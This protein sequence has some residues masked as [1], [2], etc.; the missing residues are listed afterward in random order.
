MGATDQG[1]DPAGGRWMTIP[2]TLCFITNGSDVLLMKRGE[3]RRVFPGRYNGIGGHLERNEDP[4]TGA[5]REIIEETGLDVTDLRLRGI[6]NVD[7]GQAAGI[8]LFTFTAVAASRDL[9]D[10]DEGTL[11]W[12]PMA[13]VNDLPLVEDLPLLLPRL[14]GENASSEIFFAHMRYDK[15]DR[16]ILTFA[17]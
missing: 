13:E 1:A 8:M 7:A 2:R 9:I 4:I 11:H 15:Q 14:F 10:C 17:L 16:V 12:V 5:R 3:N 6:T